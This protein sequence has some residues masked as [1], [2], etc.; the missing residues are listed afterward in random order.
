MIWPMQTLTHEEVT[1]LGMNRHQNE[2]RCE[3][4]MGEGEENQAD[5]LWFVFNRTEE[6][7][8]VNNMEIFRLF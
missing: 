6:R 1:G 8:L 5:G 4:W 3:K 2:Q 7:K